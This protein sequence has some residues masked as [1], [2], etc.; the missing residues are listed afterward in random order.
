MSIF[1]TSAEL[2]EAKNPTTLDYKLNHLGLN[3]SEAVRKAVASNPNV[4]HKF[5]EETLS[6]DSSVEVRKAVASN[7]RKMTAKLWKKLS[8]DES[9]EVRA[10]LL[11]IW[12]EPPTEL[13][14]GN[15]VGDKTR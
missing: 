3:K 9:E 5:L 14:Y 1:S 10:E 8:D 2:K 4:Q 15:G 7:S 6:I 12:P 11:K 13:L